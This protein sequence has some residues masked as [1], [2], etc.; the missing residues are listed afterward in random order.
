[1]RESRVET[2]ANVHIKHVIVVVALRVIFLRPGA[3]HV[4]TS[5]ELTFSRTLHTHHSSA[6]CY[7]P[8]IQNA[9]AS[10]FCGE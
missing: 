2:R 6:S 3:L 1:M 9:V 10:L 8:E 7:L 5:R 4:N